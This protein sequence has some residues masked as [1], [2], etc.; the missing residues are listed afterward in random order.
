MRK[1]I[2]IVALLLTGIYASAQEDINTVILSMPN[3]II[4]GLE[5]SQ[6]D[7]LVAADPSDTA[8]VTVNTKL[9][10]N[11]KRLAITN[12]YVS[13]QTSGA[14]TTQIKLLPLV[15]NSKIVCVVKTVCG[16]FCDSDIQFYTTDWK[17][18]DSSD[19]FPKKDINWFIRPDADRNNDSFK[20]AMAALDLTPMK[21]SLSGNSDTA[22]VEYNIKSYLS[23]DDYKLLEP[24]LIDEP[25]A[26]N[27]DKVSFKDR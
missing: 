2:I 17:P 4:Y 22:L 12:S 25:K 6:K 13:L 23:E 18:I 26:L 10:P 3:D 9:H 15:N 19:L 1:L 21:I 8:I 27:W 5:A 24:Y 11:I 7:L 16:G 14:A 20:N